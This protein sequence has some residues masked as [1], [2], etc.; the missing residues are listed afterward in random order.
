[1]MGIAVISDKMPFLVDLPEYFFVPGY[2][3]ANTKE[4]CIHFFFPQDP[5]DLRGIGGSRAVV[6]AQGNFFFSSGRRTDYRQ[7]KI[8]KHE[9]TTVKKDERI[10]KQ[11]DGIN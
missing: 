3:A 10:N 11:Q 6:K 8:G 2:P 9:I 7:E 5:E 1:M 4:C